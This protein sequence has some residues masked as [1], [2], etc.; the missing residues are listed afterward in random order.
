MNVDTNEIRNFDNDESAKEA[1]YEPI[2]DEL[3]KAA[4]KVLKNK[5]SVVV[6]KTGNKRNSTEAKLARFAANIRKK[7]ALD[8]NKRVSFIDRYK[9]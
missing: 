8:P 4:K 5:E 2:P 9:K 6:P 7:Q 1:G 3:Q